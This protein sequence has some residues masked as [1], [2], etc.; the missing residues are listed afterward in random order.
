[1]LLL[2]KIQTFN[3]STKQTAAMIAGGR[4]SHQSNPVNPG[5][6]ILK[7]ISTSTKYNLKAN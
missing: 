6:K 7:Q 3:P 5:L 2:N 1:M 4:A